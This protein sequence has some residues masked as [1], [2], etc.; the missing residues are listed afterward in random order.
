MINNEVIFYDSTSSYDHI[1]IKNKALGASEYQFYALIDNLQKN[2]SSWQITVYHLGHYV[3]NDTMLINV[4]NNI[5]Y[6]H[7]SEFNQNNNISKSKIIIQRFSSIELIN[8][9]KNNKIIIWLH[10]LPNCS[11]F[12]HN[13]KLASYYEQHLSEFKKI[14]NDYYTNKNISF[15]FNSYFCQTAYIDFFDKYDVRF[16]SSRMHIIYNILYENEFINLMSN[17]KISHD[18]I[19]HD[20]I[21]ININQLVYASAWN[22][23]IGK[24][25][26]LFNELAIKDTNLQLILM[27]PG[28]DYHYYTTYVQKISKLKNIR[29]LGPIDKQSF[30]KIIKTSLCVLAPSYLETFGCVFAESYYLGTPVICDKINGAIKEIIDNNY[31]VNYDNVQQVYDKVKYL[32]TVR[33]MIDINLD[34]KFKI[35]SNLQKWQL[36]LVN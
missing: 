15:V 27:T 26:N 36:L 16:E 30:G 29:V 3:K 35:D 28:Y 25:I 8:K 34:D 6:K 17:D 32:K 22:K 5:I 12:L 4:N 23:G 10:D 31:I 19:S 14:L 24:I 18:K 11:L 7:I 20:N 2:N 9:F 1:S 21:N 13:R 33:N